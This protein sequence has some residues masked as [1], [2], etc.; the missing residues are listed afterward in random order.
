[1]RILIAEDNLVMAHVLQFNLERAGFDVHTAADGELALEA[2]LENS[3]DIIITDYQMPRMNGE[4]LVQQLRTHPEYTNAPI[5]MC[6]AKGYEIDTARLERELG[7][8]EVVYKP[9]SP[10]QIVELIH[11]LTSTPQTAGV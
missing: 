6:S 4:E 7:I 9:F 5:V 1:M 2:A 11:S 3:F 10:A 8:S